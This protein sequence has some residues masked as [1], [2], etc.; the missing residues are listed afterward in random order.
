VGF[1][2]PE[3]LEQGD[4]AGAGRRHR[5]DLVTAVGAAQGF[6]LDGGVAFEIGEGDGAA[7]FRH[8]IGDEAGRLALV[9][10]TRAVFL[11]AGKDGGEIRLA[12]QSAGLVKRTVGEKNTFR[13]GELGEEFGVSLEVG[14]GALGE[15]KAIG[16]EA[17]GGFADVG[18]GDFAGA[19]FLLGES[20]AGDGAGDAAG[21]PA[22]G[23]GAG[24]GFEDVAIGAEIHVAAGGGGGGLAVVDGDGATVGEV[25]H[26]EA[27]AADVSGERIDDG[28]GETDGD[29]RVHGVAAFF[30]NF[31]AGF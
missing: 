4:T 3:H 21:A 24:T 11:K 9:E 23:G 7:V 19:V 12:P 1:Q 26:H 31:H 29:A 30:E 6:A 22:H 14:G 17:T 27:A 18:P 20:E 16:G 28:E 25:D 2:H 15:D 13:F 8:G 10:F 5:H